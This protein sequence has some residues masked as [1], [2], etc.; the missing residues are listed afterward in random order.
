MYISEDNTEQ[1]MVHI[2]RAERV[3][4]ERFEQTEVTF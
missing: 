4:E 3:Y 2:L 1:N